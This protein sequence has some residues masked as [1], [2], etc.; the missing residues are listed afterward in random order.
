M[1]LA[2]STLRAEALVEMARLATAADPT[3]TGARPLILVI[4][5]LAT[6]EA[7]ADR[8]AVIEGGWSGVFRP[9][10]PPSRAGR[11]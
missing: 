3:R 11:G 10:R 5:D 6:L 7:R 9:L 1:E 8:P 4:P 2:A